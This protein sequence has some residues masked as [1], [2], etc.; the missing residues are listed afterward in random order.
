[1]HRFNSYLVL[2][3]V[4]LLAGCDSNSEPE[5]STIDIVVGTG[6]LAD[7]RDIVTVHYTGMFRNG[8]VFDTSAE[9]GP[10]TFELETGLLQDQQGQQ[11]RLIEGFVMGVN[12]MRVGGIRRITI[13]PELGYGRDTHG[14]IPPNSTI[15]F[16]VELL[17]VEER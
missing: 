17:A 3:F 12:G 13:P 5:I 9:R 2:A 7:G 10:I 6:A 15:V 8:D 11:V 14:P 4:A 16:Q 1:M